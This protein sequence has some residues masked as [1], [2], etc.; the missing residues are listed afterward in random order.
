MLAQLSAR[1]RARQ[2]AAGGGGDG[3]AGDEGVPIMVD[4]G[5]SVGLSELMHI[6]NMADRAIDHVAW[7]VTGETSL[8]AYE[9]DLGVGVIGFG[10]TE[11]LL[12]MSAYRM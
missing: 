3:E 2:A 4:D 10:Q 5:C 11:L 6:P 12:N 7:Q 9:V 8:E 1:L